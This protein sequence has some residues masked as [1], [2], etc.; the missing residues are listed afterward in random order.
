[1]KKKIQ[2]FFNNFFSFFKKR[3]ILIFFPLVIIL[4]FFRKARPWL[5]NPFKFWDFFVFIINRFWEFLIDTLPSKVEEFYET[6]LTLKKFIHWFSWYERGCDVVEWIWRQAFWTSFSK[7]VYYDFFVLSNHMSRERIRFRKWRA[8]RWRFFKRAFKKLFFKKISITFNISKYTDYISLHIS[9]SLST[10]IY[11]FRW[12]DIYFYIFVILFK[13]VFL[14]FRLY[15]LVVKN[16]VKP[17][18]WDDLINK[19]GWFFWFI[20]WTCYLIG[21][22]IYAIWYRHQFFYDGSITE[23]DFLV[24]RQLVWRAREMIFES[25]EVWANIF[26]TSSLS[27]DDYYNVLYD[28]ENRYRASTFYYARDVGYGV[29]G[30]RD[31]ECAARGGDGALVSDWGS[32]FYYDKGSANRAFQFTDS[33]VDNLCFSYQKKNVGFMSG[34]HEICGLDLLDIGDTKYI[35]NFLFQPLWTYIYY[36]LDWLTL[37]NLEGE[38]YTI[39][40]YRPVFAR[41][42]W[43]WPGHW[44]GFSDTIY[45]DD[46]LRIGFRRRTSTEIA[47]KRFLFSE[48]D[49]EVYINFMYLIDDVEYPLRGF[50]YFNED[51]GEALRELLTI[52]NAFTFLSSGFDTM[53]PSWAETRRKRQSFWIVSELTGRHDRGNWKKDMSREYRSGYYESYSYLHRFLIRYMKWSKR[54]NWCEWKVH[55]G[56]FHWALWKGETD[57]SFWATRRFMQAFSYRNK[58][59]YYYPTLIFYYYREIFGYWLIFLPL[60]YISFIYWR[61]FAKHERQ[62]KVYFMLNPLTN[63]TEIDYL[64]RTDLWIRCFR[65]AH[66]FFLLLLF[67]WF[68]L[69]FYTNRL[70]FHIFYNKINDHIIDFTDISINLGDPVDYSDG[71]ELIELAMTPEFY[72]F[73]EVSKRFFKDPFLVEEVDLSAGALKRRDT[74]LLFE[75]FMPDWYVET[76]ALATNEFSDN[77]FYSSWFSVDSFSEYFLI[78]GLPEDFDST[79]FFFSRIDL[80]A[81]KF[82][83]ISA[84]SKRMIKSLAFEICKR[85]KELI[86]LNSEQLTQRLIKELDFFSINNINSDPPSISSSLWLFNPETFFNSSHPNS[87]FRFQ[88][89]EP[90]DTAISIRDDDEYASY[91]GRLKYL[92]FVPSNIYDFEDMSPYYIKR[93][94]LEYSEIP[95]KK[96]DFLRLFVN[97]TDR[98]FH[99]PFLNYYSLF[100]YPQSFFGSFYYV[101]YYEVVDG[102]IMCEWDWAYFQKQ[103]V[104]YLDSFEPDTEPRWDYILYQN[105]DIFNN[106]LEPEMKISDLFDLLQKSIFNMHLENVEK[107]KFIAGIC[108][109]ESLSTGHFIDKTEW[110]SSYPLKNIK[111]QFMMN[112]DSEWDIA[113]RFVNLFCP[114]S[115]PT[116]KFFSYLYFDEDHFMCDNSKYFNY[117]PRTKP[118][119]LGANKVNRFFNFR[120]HM[121][122]RVYRSVLYADVM[123]QLGILDIEN[124]QNVKHNHQAARTSRWKFYMPQTD[125]YYKRLMEASWING[126]W[127]ERAIDCDHAMSKICYYYLRAGLYQNMNR[128]IMI[129]DSIK[130]IRAEQWEN[131]EIVAP[132]NFMYEEALWYRANVL[133]DFASIGGDEPMWMWGINVTYYPKGRA[134]QFLCVTRDFGPY[135]FCSDNIKHKAAVSPY[136]DPGGFL[137]KNIWWSYMKDC[138]FFRG[139]GNVYVDDVASIDTEEYMVNWYDAINCPKYAFLNF[140]Y[141]AKNSFFFSY[142]FGRYGAGKPCIRLQSS[143]GNILNPSFQVVS[144]I[145]PSLNKIKLT[146]QDINCYHEWYCKLSWFQLYKLAKVSGLY[147]FCFL[148]KLLFVC[149]VF[150]NIFWLFNKFFIFAMKAYC[151]EEK[152]SPWYKLG[153]VLYSCGIANVI[154]TRYLYYIFYWS[155][156]FVVF[157]S[158]CWFN[159]LLEFSFWAYNGIPFIIDFLFH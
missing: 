7:F 64:I 120:Y 99:T 2:N 134:R 153:Y 69:D 90:Y 122:Q 98:I 86:Q 125:T 80:V 77:V 142:Y 78:S 91:E 8:A 41:Y 159:E 19:N 87:L 6:N 30:F 73:S 94:A 119:I 42:R 71:E 52:S 21:I 17:R 27:E 96:F 154:K 76:V 44:I 35:Y 146:L 95:S 58:P 13:I 55:T 135:T 15:I 149:W 83:L 147:W 140:H 43:W 60:F 102:L 85:Y 62:K 72:N 139:A 81:N 26:G 157:N 145:T 74:A 31:T 59:F 70:T 28:K 155:S 124:I 61:A 150:I 138:I 100:D 132:P 137:V 37:S 25:S 40:P 109:R 116:E 84:E 103:F 14:P 141:R 23:K 118:A 9:N 117:R 121:I 68:I 158:I 129:R 110:L 106:N 93:F 33:F 114:F 39:A 107:A 49:D 5:T 4:E 24:I 18:F 16:A 22:F 46:E 148:V 130:K 136:I 97:K 32:L 144:E 151:S 79:W 54:I 104:Y 67:I 88:F 75:Y 1:M 92:K 57:R 126:P 123:S 127:N 82:N 89:T 3:K 47:Y 10:F 48:F 29:K 112:R 113:N 108:Y 128:M 34:F 131:R 63:I 156:F 105:F 111:A 101:D 152:N 115:Q 53:T 51:S 45:A 66:L 143:M 11:N 56:R 36:P 12:V 50:S 133:P 65:K 20:H 38:R